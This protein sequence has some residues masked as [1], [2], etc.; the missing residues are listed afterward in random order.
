MLNLGFEALVDSQLGPDVKTPKDLYR[1]M[2]K[3]IKYGI[4]IDHPTKETDM[5]LKFFKYY[6][7]QTPEQLLKSKMGVCWDQTYFEKRWLED[8]GFETQQ[9]YI[10]LDINPA[11]PTHTF[12]IF[13]DGDDWFY[14]E[15]SFYII[16]QVTKIRNVKN[17][18]DMVI[19]AMVNEEVKKDP[20]LNYNMAKT[21]VTKMVGE[22]PYGKGVVAFMEFA[23]SFP[24]VY[25]ELK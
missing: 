20:S 23:E 24:N 8:R 13:K 7:L 3:N 25:K 19:T 2:G 21:L 17:L 1:W 22:P 10:E 9:F 14:F 18:V 12:T 16:R 11:R 4:N 15:N 6:K 5:A